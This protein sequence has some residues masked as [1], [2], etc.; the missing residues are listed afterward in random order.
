[1]RVPLLAWL[2]VLIELLRPLPEVRLIAHSSWRVFHP[3]D[4][5]REM[6][7]ERA[8]GSSAAPPAC[9]RWA[10]SHATLDACPSITDL[11]VLDDA[12]DEQVDAPPHCV[13]LCHPHLGLSDP[14]SQERLRRWLD[15]DQSAA[16]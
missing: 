8:N 2:P 1:M 12:A 5:V 3:R 16:R 13:A 11:L 6:L 10:G 7:G 14:R 9:E 15:C 4:E